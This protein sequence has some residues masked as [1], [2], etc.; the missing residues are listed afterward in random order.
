ML[1]ESSLVKKAE[2]EATEKN[3]SF[4]VKDHGSNKN[5]VDQNVLLVSPAEKTT[6]FSENESKSVDQLKQSLQNSGFPVNG[7]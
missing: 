1:E 5:V 6:V 3:I 4:I 2:K 7:C